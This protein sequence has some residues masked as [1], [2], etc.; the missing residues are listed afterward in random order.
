MPFRNDLVTLRLLV[1]Q[2]SLA[3]SQ[4]LRHGRIRR[5]NH[6]YQLPPNLGAQGH[7]DMLVQ[8][9]WFT[10]ACKTVVHYPMRTVYFLR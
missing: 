10:A 6:P 5:A 1:P 9:R 3:A 4:A 2:R 7:L 8:T